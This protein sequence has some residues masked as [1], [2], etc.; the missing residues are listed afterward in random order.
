LKF[1]YFSSHKLPKQQSTSFWSQ[2]ILGVKALA[3]K[4]ATMTLKKSWK[5]DGLHKEVESMARKKLHQT[6]NF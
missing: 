5:E 4:A 6:H 2:G 3:A 1:F